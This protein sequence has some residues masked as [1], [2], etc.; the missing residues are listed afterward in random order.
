M[1]HSFA[2]MVQAL[3]VGFWLATAQ[4]I[5]AGSV[6]VPAT[7][8][9]KL[10]AP[11]P[12]PAVKLTFRPEISFRHEP[13]L[14]SDLI[15]CE[16]DSARCA[17]LEELDY[18]IKVT[19]GKTQYVSATQ[20]IEYLK[21]EWPQTEVTFTGVASAKVNSP[22]KLLA[23]ED[24]EAAL[25]S[26]LEIL[27]AGSTTLRLT[28]EKIQMTSPLTVMEEDH[29]IIFPG[30]FDASVEKEA[31]IRGITASV[32]VAAQYK[33]KRGFQNFYIQPFLRIEEFAPVAKIS[34]QAG[35]IISK[36]HVERQ[37][38]LRPPGHQN[39]SPVSDLTDV[40]GLIAKRFIGAGAVLSMEALAHPILVKRGEQVRVSSSKNG[41]HVTMKA[42]ALGNGTA[43]Q[44]VEVETI[45]AKRRVQA[46]VLD[47][48]S[49]EV[50][51]W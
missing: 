9:A 27:T 46:R 7:A 19:P 45:G 18:G 42:M 44:L 36:A 29:E 39:E 51:Q 2:K 28:V 23:I 48:S 49:V 37:W 40:Y 22:A 17:E 4:G 14:L 47:S 31:A 35:T 8:V 34:I 6:T 12:S 3:I 30:L 32:S 26:Q 15:S 33:S 24:V 10:A 16:G 5:A 43:G 38:R 11:K 50:V 41:I 1:S 13:L 21:I 20:L 25:S